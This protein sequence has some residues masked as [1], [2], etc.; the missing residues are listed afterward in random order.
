MKDG[1]M[2][3]GWEGSLEGWAGVR[4]SHGTSKAFSLKGW[5]GRTPHNVS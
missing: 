3:D 2:E 1:G 5:L 4:L